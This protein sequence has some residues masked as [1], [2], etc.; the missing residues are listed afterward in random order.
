MLDPSEMANVKSESLALHLRYQLKH[1][2]IYLVNHKGYA[3]H[4]LILNN[5]L[6]MCCSITSC[7]KMSQWVRKLREA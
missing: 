4:H 7:F 1:M 6:V 2:P 3:D 5:V